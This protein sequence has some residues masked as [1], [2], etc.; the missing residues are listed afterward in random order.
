MIYLFEDRPA[1]MDIYLKDRD[2][3]EAIEKGEL[4]RKADFDHQNETLDNYVKTRFSDARAVLFHGT[5]RFSDGET[6]L[7]NVKNAFL[8]LNTDFITFSG[9]SD[10]GNYFND[11]QRFQGAINSG[12]MYKNLP[13][14]ITNLKKGDKPDIRLLFFGYDFLKNELLY[15]KKMTAVFL[16]DM[17]DNGELSADELQEFKDVVIDSSLGDPELKD[18]KEE[19]TNWLTNQI[20]NDV[21]PKANKVREFINSILQ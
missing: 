13:L 14:I 8:K 2:V 16:A 19:L 6:T 18:I 12:L 5:Y 4:I 3:L 17:H 11:G 7:T 20:K 15:V 10:L 21:K 1:R 9:G